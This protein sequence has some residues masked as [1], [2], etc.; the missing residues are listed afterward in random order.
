MPEKLQNVAAEPCLGVCWCGV[1]ATE[2]I[3]LMS[4]EVLP[5]FWTV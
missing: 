1:K 3:A 4:F 2:K 5:A